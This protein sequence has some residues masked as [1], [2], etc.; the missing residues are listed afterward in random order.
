A[1]AATAVPDGLRDSKLVTPRRRPDVAARTAEWV[2]A[3]AL[4]WATPGEVDE[5]GIL[6]ALGLAAV[7]AL[8]T[9]RASGLDAASGIVLLDGNHDYLS[10]V[11]EATMGPL[12]LRTVVGGDR[13]RA[14][15][16]A[17]SIA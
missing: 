16:S 6:G 7:R 8:A 3:S 12:N 2:C 4:G 15:I 10:P 11:A 13:E 9:L 1:V 17:A 14:S 5:H